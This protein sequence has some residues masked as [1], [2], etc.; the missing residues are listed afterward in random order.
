MHQCV[1]SN[2]TFFIFSFFQYY[3]GQILDTV[4]QYTL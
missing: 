4:K 1:G 3:L 2:A